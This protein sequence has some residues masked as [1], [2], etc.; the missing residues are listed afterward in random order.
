MESV[1]VI[2]RVPVYKSRCSQD[3][4]AHR[5][6]TSW[7]YVI[8]TTCLPL[9]ASSSWCGYSAKF[10]ILAQD[11]LPCAKYQAL[12]RLLLSS[13]VKELRHLLILVT[14]MLLFLLLITTFGLMTKLLCHFLRRTGRIARTVGTCPHEPLLFCAFCWHLFKPP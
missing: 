14:G 3:A 11:P 4:P 2:W 6:E 7:V 9:V 13:S 12:S 8:Q 5:C 10:P 1:A